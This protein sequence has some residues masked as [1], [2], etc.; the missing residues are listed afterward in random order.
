MA[1]FKVVVLRHG[2]LSTE[3]ERRVVLAAGGT[4]VDTDGWPL[5]AALKECEEAEGMLVRWFPLG[6]DLLRRFGR[7]RIVVRY[8]VGYDN[9][10]LAAA[11]AAGIM[12][13]HAPAYCCDEVATHTLALLL[14]CVRN[15]VTIHQR[16]A[17]GGWE[18][19]PPEK[20]HR[21]AGR[22]FGLVGFGN[23]GQSV[24]R[25]LGGWGMRLLATDPYVEPAR[26][27]AVGVELV[28]LEA[29]CRQSDYVSLHVPLLPE[30][31]HLIG[32][33]EFEWMK[34]GV[35]VVNTARGPVLDTAALLA[36]LNAGR[37]NAAGLDVFEEEPLAASSPLR[38]HPRVVLSDH[39]AWYSEESLAELQR[40]VAEEAVRVC[41]GGLPVALANPEVLQRLGRASE[42]TPNDSARWQLKRLAHQRVPVEAISA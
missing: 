18:P 9:V 25:K 14:A 6:L 35:T 22:T 5:D 30:T 2:Y 17:R 37:V 24:A 3:T 29:L 13:G 33:R 12:V 19:N 39:T 27:A 8:G 20:S 28:D 7:C 10:D 16:L 40:T 41:T 15:A 1:G 34:S 38:G 21:M 11:T 36:A 32:R 26:A 42:W 23:I 4:L 31:R